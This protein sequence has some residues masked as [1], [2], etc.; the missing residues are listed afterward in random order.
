MLRKPEE[1]RN[2][3]ECIHVGFF[4]I[5]IKNRR[6]QRNTEGQKVSEEWGGNWG[7]S[8]RLQDHW[9]SG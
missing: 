9:R 1:D 8:Y 3:H 4:D 7:Q 2:G 5:W 6:K